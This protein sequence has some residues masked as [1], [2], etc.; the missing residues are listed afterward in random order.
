VFIHDEGDLGGRSVFVDA[1]A[2]LG[3]PSEKVTFQGSASIYCFT[4]VTGS[5]T[6]NTGAAGSTANVFGTAL[7]NMGLGGTTI[8]QRGSSD[9]VN[10]G[11]VLGLGTLANINGPLT[12]HND[13][14]LSDLN[15]HDELD[16]VNHPFAQIADHAIAGLTPFPIYTYF[17]S[18][19]N[20]SVF[21]G[22]GNNTYLLTGSPAHN[23][24]LETGPGQD[25][26]NVQ[27]NLAYTTIATTTGVGGG[28]NDVVNLGTPAGSVIG[29]LFPVYIYNSRSSDHV[30][31]N[32][33]ADSSTRNVT[34]S[35]T[36]PS[37][38]VAGLAPAEINFAAGSVS[39]LSVS[40]GTG[41]NTYTVASTPASDLVVLDTGSGTD[42]TNVQT[43]TVPLRVNTTTGGGGGGNDVVNIGYNNSVA[44]I[45]RS[46]AISNGPSYDRI[47]I[48]D[49]ADTANHPGVVISNAG[50]A[51]GVT[52]LA[53]AGIYFNAAFCNQLEVNTGGGTNTVTIPSTPALTSVTLNTSAV[54]AAAVNLQGGGARIIV[55]S[56]GADTVT[57]HNTGG[58]VD[59]FFRGV[60]VNG[61]GSSTVVVDDSSRN[62]DETYSITQNTVTA[63]RLG[64]DPL[65]TY[66]G[67]GRLVVYGGTAVTSDLYTIDSTSCPLDVIGGAG[68]TGI[69]CFSISPFSNSLASITAPLNIVGGGADVISFWDQY[70]PNSETYNFDSVPG[71]LTLTTLPVAINFSGMGGGV[72]LQTN[73]MSTVNDLSGTVIVDGTPP[74]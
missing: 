44:G 53:P 59:G 20:L 26:T 74:C 27:A 16:G 24:Q 30:N 69:N 6:V 28:G 40:G 67:L 51:S 7:F 3:F 13:A 45:L 2:D 33:S 11:G 14:G 47:Y 54:G 61:N 25:T 19:R 35:N 1:N 9:V 62:R 70:N 73:G 50:A 60:A 31:I 39:T 5:L 23:V 15:I 32:G 64:V 10:V 57:I 42:A 36:G 65:L 49:S 52:G 37:A 43:T 17:G 29:I 48:N 41:D 4:N 56:A 55:N 72:Y 66:S 12:L 21:G 34:L 58:T 38:G 22:T 18:T 71:Q 68:G 46:V 63:A 8:N